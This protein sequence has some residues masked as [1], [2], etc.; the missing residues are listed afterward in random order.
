FPRCGCD[1]DEANAG[2]GGVWLMEASNAAGDSFSAEVPQEG[3][4][5]P[6]RWADLFG[7]DRPVEVE[8]GFGKG[9]FLITAGERFPEVN[10][11]GVERRLRYFRV[12]RDRIEK[13]NLRNVRI[14]RTDAFALVHAVLPAASVRAY[15]VY[16]PDPWWKKRHRKRRIFTPDFVDGL[17]RT[18]SPGGRLYVASDVGEYFEEIRALVE[19]RPEFRPL[20]D[21]GGRMEAAG[22][23]PSNFE[24]KMSK[25]GHPIHRAVYQRPGAAPPAPGRDPGE[26]EGATSPFAL[27]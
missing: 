9:R 20:D 4:G 14:V 13:R 2:A 7:N 3:L 22:Y 18:L 10:Y 16:F 26:S 25:A 5:R 21:P 6:L 24:V 19:G 15:H 11:F 12:A 17:A 1:A 8:I 23:V 27:A